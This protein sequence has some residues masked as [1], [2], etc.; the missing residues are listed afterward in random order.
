[1]NTPAQPSNQFGAWSDKMIQASD[2]RTVIERTLLIDCGQHVPILSQRP[3]YMGMGNMPFRGPQGQQL[4]HQFLFEI[5]GANDL[6][7][8]FAL[9]VEQVEAAGKTEAKR[10]QELELKQR[11]AGAG[12]GR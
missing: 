9:M 7:E 12:R 1:M 5:N 2:G 6:I 11:L 3:I 10:L 4:N 8:A